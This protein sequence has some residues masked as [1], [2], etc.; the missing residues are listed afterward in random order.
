LHDP[1]TQTRAS[2]EP[3]SG[4]RV[5]LPASAGPAL[6]VT[7]AVPQSAPAPEVQPVHNVQ[8]AAEKQIENSEPQKIER[9]R[10]EKDRK[11]EE[12]DR[13]AERRRSA[14]RKAKRLAAER[15]RQRIQPQPREEFGVMAFGGDETR[16]SSFEPRA[17]FFGN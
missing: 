14:E 12:K 5:I 8:P 9:E 15:A 2:S 11:A 10:I 13:K 4:M 6:Q 7:A 1:P 17:S 16:T 3:S